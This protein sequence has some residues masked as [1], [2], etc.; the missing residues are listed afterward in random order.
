MCLCVCVCVCVDCLFGS[1]V[2]V[3]VCVYVPCGLSLLTFS[4]TGH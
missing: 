4:V 2:K 3:Q 1:L